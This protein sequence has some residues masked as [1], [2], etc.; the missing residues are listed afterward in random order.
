MKYL[1]KGSQF[2]F[3]DLYPS[4]TQFFFFFF[5]FL[6]KVLCKKRCSQKFRKIH[7][8]TPVPESLFHKVAGLRPAAL[9][10]RPWHRP[11]T[12]PKKR[13]CHKCFVVNFARFLRSPFYRTPPG[14]C[15]CNSEGYA[16]LNSCQILNSR[17]WHTDRL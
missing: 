2:T 5:F 9:K 11:P 12:L 13:L 10:K 7:R 14:D 1:K 3:S 8:K 17:L 6:P 4:R 16:F 15:S